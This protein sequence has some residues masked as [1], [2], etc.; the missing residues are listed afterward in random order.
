MT[1]ENPDAF[2]DQLAEAALATGAWGVIAHVMKFCDPYLARL[3][4]I[5]ERLEEAGLPVLVL[6]GDCTLRS[7]GQHA[8]RV[9]AFAE[10]LTEMRP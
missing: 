3:P 2:A 5:R 6:E 10:M 1:P 9:E 8:T 7:L 4:S